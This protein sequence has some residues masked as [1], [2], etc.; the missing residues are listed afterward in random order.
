[1]L[2]RIMDVQHSL[3]SIRKVRT[4]CPLILVPSPG[5]GYNAFYGDLG[6]EERTERQTFVPSIEPG[7][8]D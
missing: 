8:S 2:F 3:Y 6:E 4:L 5:D 1:M 7:R